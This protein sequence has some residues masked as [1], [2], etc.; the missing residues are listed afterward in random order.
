MIY[1]VVCCFTINFIS[2]HITTQIELRISKP[3][4]WDDVIQYPQDTS[5]MLDGKKNIIIGDVDLPIVICII[6]HPKVW[7]CLRE[8]EFNQIELV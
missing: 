1:K 5:E 4:Q 7:I 2:Y 8:S 3:Y 6:L